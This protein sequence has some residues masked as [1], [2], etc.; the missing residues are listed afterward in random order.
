V[1]LKEIDDAEEQ[2]REKEL[3]SRLSQ[4]AIKKRSLLRPIRV[5][6]ASSVFPS[7]FPACVIAYDVDRRQRAVAFRQNDAASR[8]QYRWRAYVF[9]KHLKALFRS[10]WVRRWDA[11]YGMY[12]YLNTRTNVSSWETPAC[13][14]YVP[15]EPEDGPLFRPRSSPEHPAIA[16][17]PGMCSPLPTHA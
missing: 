3:R 7:P 12:Y 1:Q 16:D 13:L 9:R 11:T 17:A 5:C 4:L 14:K 15:I 10:V 2:E 6:V 8:F